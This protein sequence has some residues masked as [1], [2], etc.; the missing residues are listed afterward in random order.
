LIRLTFCLDLMEIKNKAKI[1]IVKGTRL[2]GVPDPVGVLREGQVY[3]AVKVHQGSRL[4]GS[5][6]G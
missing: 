2:I 3:C 1:P 4:E 6:L 5:T